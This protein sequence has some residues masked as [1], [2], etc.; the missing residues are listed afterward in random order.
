[1]PTLEFNHRWRREG[2][3]S[4]SLD[5]A[6]WPLKLENEM[7]MKAV[8]SAPPYFSQRVPGQHCFSSVGSEN[9]GRIPV[10]EYVVCCSWQEPSPILHFGDVEAEVMWLKRVEQRLET[11]LLTY[12]SASSLPHPAS[13]FQPLTMI[14]KCLWVCD[15]SPHSYP[16]YKLRPSSLHFIED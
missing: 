9:S 1:M 13:L 10:L 7:E 11:H 16:A 15:S 2:K 12:I 14:T 4:Y 6:A 5:L 3:S 8:G